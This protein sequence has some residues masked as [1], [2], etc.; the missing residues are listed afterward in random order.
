MV[1]FAKTVGSRAE[2]MHCVAYQTAGGLTK[3]DL[4]KDKSGVRIVSKAQ[5]KLNPGAKLWMNAVAKAR[6]DEKT[7]GFVLLK[8]GEPLYERAKEIYESM[9]KKAAKK[10]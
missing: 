6:K 2:V 8:Q 3:K 1:E 7:K 9:K 10:K 4:K 5:Q